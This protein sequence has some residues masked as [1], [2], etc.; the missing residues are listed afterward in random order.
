MA[1]KDD[2]IL[3]RWSCLIQNAK[4]R[5]DNIYNKVGGILGQLEPHCIQTLSCFLPGLRSFNLTMTFSR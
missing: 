4:G 2:K 1:L 5:A 3:E